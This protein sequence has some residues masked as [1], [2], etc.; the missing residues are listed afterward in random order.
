M[1][2]FCCFA[3]LVFFAASIQTA[4]SQTATSQNVKKPPPEK[5]DSRQQKASTFSGSES[6]I[7]N[8][9]IVHA[10][11]TPGPQPEWRVINKPKHGELRFERMTVPVNLKENTPRA[12]CNGKPI[13]AVGV[14]YKSNDSFVGEDRIILDVNYKVGFISR[15]VYVV[16]VR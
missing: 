13:D 8:L 3:V 15:H 1:P 16:D 14:F 6:R 9:Y 5:I 7:S 10:D 4:T 11:C 2:L 12:H